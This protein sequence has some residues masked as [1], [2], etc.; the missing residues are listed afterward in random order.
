[1]KKLSEK[2]LREIGSHGLQQNMTIHSTDPE[3]ASIVIGIVLFFLL[4]LIFGAHTFASSKDMQIGVSITCEQQDWLVLNDQ[5]KSFIFHW[6]DR[7]THQILRVEE[8]H[9]DGI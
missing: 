5:G 3:C 8:V 1:M 6:C 4:S 2:R 7:E 9:G